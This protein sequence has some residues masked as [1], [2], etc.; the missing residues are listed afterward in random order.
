MRCDVLLGRSRHGPLVGTMEKGTSKKGDWIRQK[1]EVV[2]FEIGT[3]VPQKIVK[4]FH[5]ASDTVIFSKRRKISTFC[6][7]ITRVAEINARPQLIPGLRACGPPRLWECTGKKTREG[8]GSA[9]V[10]K[11]AFAS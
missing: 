11:R 2:L 1:G 3:V 10:E 8:D 7:N 9:A 4:G 6:R 5:D